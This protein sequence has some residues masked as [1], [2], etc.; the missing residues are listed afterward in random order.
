MPRDAALDPAPRPRTG[1]GLG[2]RLFR[3]VAFLIVAFLIVTIAPVAILRFVHPIG[4]MFMLRASIA[5]AGDA[6]YRTQY[7]W[8]DLSHI[9]ANAA[10]A[11]IASEDQL[12]PDHH[13]FDLESIRKAVESNGR[14]KR[15]R[16]ASTIS[17]QTAKNL[18][19]WSGKSYFR[20]ALEAWFTVL[21]EAMWPKTRILEVYLNIVEFGRGVYGVE[22]A[23]RKFFHKSA[24]QLTRSEAALLAAVLPNPRRL[25]VDRPSAYVLSRRDWI[26][27][28]M[29]GL[30]G[31]EYLKEIELDV[32][33]RGRTRRDR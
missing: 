18:F 16:G 10:L 26:Q 22:T 29:R 6:T 4:S 20:K 3:S 23:S 1:T 13:G 15:I 30:G 31:W 21:I 12:F 24:A 11:V 28:Q 5:A 25:R 8:V 9:S 27:G 33:A 32:T 17:Q 14:G 19:L 2:R 7:E